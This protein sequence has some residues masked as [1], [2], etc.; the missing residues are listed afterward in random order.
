MP[1]KRA[2]SCP[3]Y[4]ASNVQRADSK[5]TADLTLAGTECNIHGQDLKDLKFVAEWQTGTSAPHCHVF[6]TRKMHLWWS[7]LQSYSGEVSTSVS[8]NTLYYRTTYL[9]RLLIVLR[10]ASPHYYI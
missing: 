8:A 1:L 7:K 3:G 2:D 9:E 6:P 5:F 4:M 10:F